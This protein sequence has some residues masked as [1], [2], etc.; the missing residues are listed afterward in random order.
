MGHADL[1]TRL[2]NG[3]VSMQ[4][5]AAELDGAGRPLTMFGYIGGRSV[6]VTETKDER[7]DLAKYLNLPGENAK[8]VGY[9]STMSCNL[10]RGADY[11]CGYE[12]IRGFSRKLPVIKTL[13]R[14]LSF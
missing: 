6:F 3:Q 1:I 4:G 11:N 8:N 10:R 7:P 12:N 5:W 13:A 14:I 2:P 9:Q